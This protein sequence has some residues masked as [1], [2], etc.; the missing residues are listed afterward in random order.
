MALDAT[1]QIRMNSE[2]K[3]QVE[4][5]YR[6][7]GTS[8][9]EAVRIFAQQSLREGRAAVSPPPSKPEDA[10]DSRLDVSTT[11]LCR[12]RGSDHC[13]W[14]DPVSCA[15]WMPH[16]RERLSRGKAIGRFELIAYTEAA[17]PAILEEAAGRISSHQ[18]LETP[19]AAVSLLVSPAS[20]DHARRQLSTLSIQMPTV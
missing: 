10:S 16:M 6:N 4:E 3:A 15:N 1:C 13:R 17:H 5:L 2:L 19:P 8:F 11:R 9:A 14:S 7:L 18:P 12:S 20:E